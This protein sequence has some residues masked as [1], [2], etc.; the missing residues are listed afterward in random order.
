MRKREK[1]G[2]TMKIKQR[3]WGKKK[4]RQQEENRRKYVKKK[5]DKRRGYY[6]NMTEKK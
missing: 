5:K 2:E 4:E 6:E 3:S 1:L